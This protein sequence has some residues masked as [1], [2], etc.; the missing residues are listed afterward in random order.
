MSLVSATQ[1]SQLST[2]AAVSSPALPIIQRTNVSESSPKAQES[3]IKA[4]DESKVYKHPLT[5]RTVLDRRDK[6]R[7][8]IY[9]IGPKSTCKDCCQQKKAESNAKSNA[10]IKPQKKVFVSPSETDEKYK[11]SFT[12]KE[13]HTFLL[14]RLTRGKLPNLPYLVGG[15]ASHVLS[16]LSHA[17]VDICYNIPPNHL[18]EISEKVKEF[19]IDKL[20]KNGVQC[21]SNAEWNHLVNHYFHDKFSDDKSF[22]IFSI[23]P[24]FQLKFICDSN[25]RRST[26]AADGFHISLLHDQDFAFC[27]NGAEPCDDNGFKKG[28]KELESR[29][30]VVEKPENTLKLIFRIVHKITQGFT[31]ENPDTVI[32]AS[33]TS[34]ITKEFPLSQKKEELQSYYIKHLNSHYPNDIRGK[35]IDFLNFLRILQNIEGDDTCSQYTKTII[36]AWQKEFPD[37]LRTLTSFLINYPNLINDLLRLIE[38]TYFLAWTKGESNIQ[39]YPIFGEGVIH[40]HFE[41]KH[42][43]GVHYY[44]H[45]QKPV[46]IADALLMAW[47]FLLQESERLKIQVPF[48]QI[49]K[50]I[51][52]QPLVFSAENRRAVAESLPI[53]FDSKA[54]NILPENFMASPIGL[55]EKLQKETDSQK[56]PKLINVFKLKRELKTACKLSLTQE[57]KLLEHLIEFAQSDSEIDKQSLSALKVSIQGLKGCPN[58]KN[59]TLSS[60]IVSDNIVSV[61]RQIRPKSSPSLIRSAKNLALAI[62]ERDFLDESDRCSGA[63]AVLSAS[64]QWLGPK[65]PEQTFEILQLA[66]EVNR[67]PIKSASL[68]KLM[69]SSYMNPLHSMIDIAKKMLGTENENFFFNFFQAAIDS[70][71]IGQNREA[72]LQTYYALIERSIHSKSAHLLQKAVDYTKIMIGQGVIPDATKVLQ[73]ATKWLKGKHQKQRK[74][75]LELL[76]LI[77]ELPQS[78]TPECYRSIAHLYLKTLANILTN[79]EPPE[80]K[81]KNFEEFSKSFKVFTDKGIKAI[82]EITKKIRSHLQESAKEYVS[83]LVQIDPPFA[84]KTFTSSNIQEILGHEDR[85]FISWALINAYSKRS[86]NAQTVNHDKSQE[87]SD[88][89]RAY[90]LWDFVRE[91]QVPGWNDRISSSVNLLKA[92]NATKYEMHAKQIEAIVQQIVVLINDNSQLF[93]KLAKDQVTKLSSALAVTVQLLTNSPDFMSL[94]SDLQD[95]A[96]KTKMLDQSQVNNA[97]L[98]SIESCLNKS[99]MPHEEILDN[100]TELFIKNCANNSDKQLTN[101]VHRL[102]KMLVALDY[103][104]AMKLAASYFESKLFATPWDND[105]ED[106]A[107]SLLNAFEDNPR[108]STR[109][110][111]ERCINAITSN[112]FFS[113]FSIPSQMAALKK[114]AECGWEN[115][116]SHVWTSCKSLEWLSKEP[117]KGLIPLTIVLSQSSFPNIF[118]WT[119][120]IFIL[121]GRKS[122]STFQL[123]LDNLKKHS[124]QNYLQLID[125]D[126]QSGFLE[127]PALPIQERASICCSLIKLFVS[128]KPHA[129]ASI[130]QKKQFEKIL[131][132]FLLQAEKC[133]T[134]SAEDKKADYVAA[135]R[136]ADQF[137][138]LPT[139]HKVLMSQKHISI[140]SYNLFLSQLLQHPQCTEMFISVSSDISHNFFISNVNTQE[141]AQTCY[142][143][144]QFA[145]EASKNDTI[146]KTEITKIIESVK[147]YALTSFKKFT[148]DKLHEVIEKLCQTHHEGLLHFVHHFSMGDRHENLEIYGFF[149][150]HLQHINPTRDWSGIISGDLRLMQLFEDTSDKSIILPLSILTDFATAVYH[151]SKHHRSDV[152]RQKMYM[153]DVG[154][155]VQ[156]IKKQKQHTID[157][158]NQISK[159][160]IPLILRTSKDVKYLTSIYN[161]IN[162]KGKEVFIPEPYLLIEMIDSFLASECNEVSFV[163]AFQAAFKFVMSAVPLQF[164]QNEFKEFC[165]R[166]YILQTDPTHLHLFFGFLTAL[167]QNPNHVKFAMK[168][169]QRLFRSFA[170]T[171][172]GDGMSTVHSIIETYFQDHRKITPI[173]QIPIE[174][175][176]QIYKKYMLSLGGEYDSKQQHE[177]VMSFKQVI[178]IYV[179]YDPVS[180]VEILKKLLVQFRSALP[181]IIAMLEEA[182]SVTLFYIYREKDSF[183]KSTM[184]DEQIR[185][186][187]EWRIKTELEIMKIHLKNTPLQSNENSSKIEMNAI[188]KRLQ[189]FYQLLTTPYLTTERWIT[190]PQSW[191]YFSELVLELS[192]W[193]LLPLI[194]Y[195]D[196][197]YFEKFK[198][199][200]IGILHYDKNEQFA[201]INAKLFRSF[202][203]ELSKIECADTRNIFVKQIAKYLISYNATPL[204]ADPNHKSGKHCLMRVIEEEVHR[205][206]YNEKVEFL[207]LVDNRRLTLMQA[208]AS[209]TSDQNLITLMSSL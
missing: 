133:M 131:N 98:F 165:L 9:K 159:T 27:V 64:E 135:L 141:I 110:E 55:F 2:A 34:L 203:V 87:A 158:V 109:Q 199:V 171:G 17:D 61:L 140:E 124:I 46:E 29:I 154:E 44:I 57:K 156:Y 146:P 138:F 194:K 128:L 3:N 142:L 160:E 193:V 177:I 78:K 99:V 136:A 53:L 32:N 88:L 112:D 73:L 172:K 132:P 176:L 77:K 33:L 116:F 167:C 107:I 71:E 84:D 58:F 89:T 18:P 36:E 100:F 137:E 54:M 19:I 145:A 153:Q 152:R 195:K 184:S 106:L 208:T 21:T 113:R 166:L 149:A 108:S 198:D 4:F 114:F 81:Q 76:L 157:I 143:L 50:E 180:G 111:W 72:L 148:L 186:A 1:N 62:F 126:L 206:N 103:S 60:Q 118:L 125:E 43:K 163:T 70:I 83:L 130:T 6:F 150:K 122:L 105:K 49:C 79:G 147:F 67:W 187:I 90:Q 204:Y 51:G 92:V 82:N 13:L 37:Q 104:K 196:S 102:I 182:D 170:E 201:E 164:N 191:E 192:N 207:S 174:K 12:I 42:S 93:E 161:A 115:M 119:R 38:G 91:S 178:S 80:T 127:D 31:V 68:Q 26:S 10:S 94:G 8:A 74:V 168:C 11:I 139:A 134:G 117:D 162:T 5:D 23:G 179:N 65:F 123:W 30:L 20:T 45:G 22:S 144:F 185:D 205:L 190:S 151:L 39:S 189:K 85:Q 197:E 59:G 183:A 15:A 155:I 97:V 181:A 40:P 48:E 66:Q 75:G 188:L 96:T 63:E 200:F 209:L 16:E 25:H 101:I 41:I 169:C 52:V 95:V 24:Y 173:L 175:S 35:E 120:K 47:N 56:I 14:E 28:L 86:L 7:D 69:A 202:F 129:N 121:S